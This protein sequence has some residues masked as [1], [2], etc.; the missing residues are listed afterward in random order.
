MGKGWAVVAG[1][2]IAVNSTMASNSARGTT[3]ELYAVGLL[4]VILLFLRLRK[5]IQA[6]HW[7][8]AVLG[9]SLGCLILIRQDGILLIAPIFVACFVKERIEKGSLSALLDSGL[10]VAIPLLTIAMCGWYQDLYEI[11]SSFWRGARSYFWFDF[12]RGR[13]PW[14]YMFYAKINLFDWWFGYHTFAE[15]LW[16]GIKSTVRTVMA[17]GQS[18]WGFHVLCLAILGAVH[19][20]RKERDL[21]L[22]LAIPLSLIPQLLWIVFS[23]NEDAFRYIVRVL[24]LVI[25]LAVLGARIVVD[26]VPRLCKTIGLRRPSAR[27]SVGV[28]TSAVLMLTVIP[29]S[30]YGGILPYVSYEKLEKCHSLNTRIHNKLVEAWN[31]FSS[32]ILDSSETQKRL[33]TLLAEQPLYAPTYYASGMVS[34]ASGSLSDAESRLEEALDI[35]PYFAEAGMF[36]A[37]VYLLQKREEDAARLLAR[38]TK[39]RPDC[40]VL[41]LQYANVLQAANTPTQAIRE[42][43]LFFEQ[44]KIQSVESLLRM[45]RIL[46]RSGAMDRAEAAKRQ[47]L[48]IEGADFVLTTPIL[49][50]YQGLDLKG[51]NIPMPFDRYACQNLGL[52]FAQSGRYAEAT[53]CWK[54]ATIYAPSS[55]SSWINLAVTLIDTGDLEKAE[56]ALRAGIKTNPNVAALWLSMAKVSGLKGSMTYARTCYEKAVQLDPHNSIAKEILAHFGEGS[57]VEE[58]LFHRH[59]LELV[60][61]RRVL[62]LTRASI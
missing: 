50:Q 25:V 31:L 43:Q 14:E 28:L 53:E 1:T 56:L 32:G 10:L 9:T 61:D 51:L 19:Y 33:E 34:L 4:I 13:M 24:P 20:V 38:L 39:E 42:Y 26:L 7:E 22:L 5:R 21:V 35:V 55:V 37:E 44:N 60:A 41:H 30:A 47:R 36:L 27:L 17:I 16:I 6:S 48:R 15:M 8:Y 23:S 29:G 59:K 52:L 62:P 3:E 45:E 12:F 54:A 58:E 18:L 2:L 57:A 46:K 49:W 40:S 11:K